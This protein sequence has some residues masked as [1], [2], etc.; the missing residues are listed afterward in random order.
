MTK[1]HRWAKPDPVDQYGNVECKA[2]GRIQSPSYRACVFCC[3]HAELTFVEG[4]HGSDDCG[5]WELEVECIACGKDHEFS[6][7]LLKRLYKVVR[8]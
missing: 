7:D 2:C 4:W 5:S 6:N 8:K 1:D 3:P